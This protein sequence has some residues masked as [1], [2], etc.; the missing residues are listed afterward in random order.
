MVVQGT[1]GYY[2][3]AVWLVKGLCVVVCVVSSWTVMCV[4]VP[5]CSGGYEV[6]I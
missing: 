4:C 6:H 1:I 2:D 3:V 5:C